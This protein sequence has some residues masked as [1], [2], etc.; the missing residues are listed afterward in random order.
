MRD[1]RLERLVDAILTIAQDVDLPV[2]LQRIV[3]AA[4]ELVDAR[5]AALGVIGENQFLSEFVHTG[6]PMAEV[7]K[8]GE[9]PQGHGILGLLIEHPEP[10]RLDDLT[11][12]PDSYGFPEHH[13]AM[14]TFLGTPIRVGGEVFGNLYL[15]E[16]RG[17]EGFTQD[18]EDLT[19]ALAAVAGAAI[20]RVNLHQEVRRMVV[21]ED[22]ERIGRDLH[23][24]VIQRLFATG[25]GLQAA[26]RMAAGDHPEIEQRITASVE[27]LDQTIREIRSTIFALQSGDAVGST[28]RRSI[29][30]LARELEP[31]LG[32]PVTVRFDGPVDTL[33]TRSLADHVAP[34]VREGLTNVAKHADASRARVTLEIGDDRLCVLVEDDGR[35]G[36]Q[37]GE[38]YGLGNLRQRAEREGGELELGES[39]FGGTALRWE[40]PL[41]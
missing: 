38:G 34:V 39:E 23:D 40:V 21:L 7:A 1:E 4:A 41:R 5:Y 25:L 32:F 11:A 18:D 26:A 20:E 2:V 29:L 12:H 30:A 35:G 6:I 13:P 22:R 28:L 9:L 37:P 17:G 3:E 10:I 31:T 24:T 33:V 8:I 36:A 15:A 27:S 14:E 16:K 19:V